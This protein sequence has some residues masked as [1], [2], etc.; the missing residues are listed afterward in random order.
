[1]Q[2]WSSQR[3]ADC[4]LLSALIVDRVV[5][6]AI[7]LGCLLHENLSDVSKFLRAVSQQRYVTRHVV[8]LSSAVA[9]RKHSEVD[10]EFRIT[11]RHWRTSTALCVASTVHRRNSRICRCASRAAAVT[12][13]SVRITIITAHARG[14]SCEAVTMAI[15][16][17][18]ITAD[19]AKT[20]SP[21]KHVIILIGENRGLDHTFGV[22]SRRA[23]ADPS[24][25]CCR[26]ASSTRT[27]RRAELR[28]G[29]AVLGRGSAV[30]LYRRARN[31]E[32]ALQRDQPDAAAE[33][34]RHADR[35]ERHRR[36]RSRRSPKPASKRT[37]IRPISISSTTGF[38]GL[39]TGVLDTRV[40][41]AGSARTD[42][43][44]C[45]ARA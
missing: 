2:S 18:R 3:R 36:L 45:R 30:V 33:H 43:S 26:R 32:V 17:T 4:E 14:R 19:K 39:P 11:K 25:T 23:R 35:A 40:P 42:R 37:W 24:R 6:D 28:A 9:N 21:I 31:R 27:E 8:A 44:R 41:G 15:M 22:Y 10:N 29:A 1:M 34:Q 5:C 20:A 13:T 16:V 7:A 12:G 38:S